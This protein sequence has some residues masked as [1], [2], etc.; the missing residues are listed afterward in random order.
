[1]RRRHLQQTMCCI[2]HG[3][4]VRRRLR[5][6][7]RCLYR[8]VLRLL[9]HL[10]AGIRHHYVTELVDRV[11]IRYLKRRP[12]RRVRAT[13]VFHFALLDGAQR[14]LFRRIRCRVA[15]FADLDRFFEQLVDV[16]SSLLANASAFRQRCRNRVQLNGV[17]HIAT[18]RPQIDPRARGRRQEKRRADATQRLLELYLHGIAEFLAHGDDL[19]HIPRQ[20]TGG[21]FVLDVAVV[22]DLQRIWQGWLD[23]HKLFYFD[24]RGAKGCHC[25]LLKPFGT[26]CQRCQFERDLKSRPLAVCELFVHDQNGHL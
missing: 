10:D 14:W 6:S 18:N 11:R 22:I 16:H 24:Q 20:I 15:R 25:N 7:E 21:R 1:M 13:F 8:R 4:T 17:G 3:V 5:W 2:E 19:G 23:I 12:R 26:V 9:Y